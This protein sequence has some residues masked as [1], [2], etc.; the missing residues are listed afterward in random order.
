MDDWRFLCQRIGVANDENLY[1]CL[2]KGLD[3]YRAY[4]TLC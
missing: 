4:A 2:A 1:G 3:R